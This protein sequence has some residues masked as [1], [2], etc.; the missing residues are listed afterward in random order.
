MEGGRVGLPSR[1]TD[2][3]D[4][5]LTHCRNWRSEHMGGVWGSTLEHGWRPCSFLDSCCPWGR[6]L[7][8]ECLILSNISQVLPNWRKDPFTFPRNLLFPSSIPYQHIKFQ[9]MSQFI[10]I[11]T[12]WL[13]TD[14]PKG[15]PHMAS[16]RTLWPCSPTWSSPPSWSLLVRNYVK[17]K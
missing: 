6:P 8:W 16:C 3:D 2:P 17:D 10:F 11:F 14:W 13:D 7:N 1:W 15:C 9:P 12:I 5:A 4:Y